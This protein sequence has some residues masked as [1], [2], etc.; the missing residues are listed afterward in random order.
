MD[1]VIPKTIHYC[2]FGKKPLNDEAIRCI[3]SWKKYFPD[4]QIVQWDE[5]NFDFSKCDYAKEAYES[6]KWAF[7]SDYARFKI[8]HEH[9]GIYFDTDVEVIKS[10]DD[11]LENGPF[12][13]KERSPQSFKMINPGLGMAAFPKMKFYEEVV[14]YYEKIHYD[15]EEHIT[16]CDHVTKMFQENGYKGDNELEVIGGITLYPIEYFCPRDYLTGAQFLTNNSHSIHLYS[17]T[18]QSEKERK[19][20][21]F[22]HKLYEKVKLNS[23][24]CFLV[25][26]AM[27]LYFYGVINCA[28]KFMKKIR[29][30]R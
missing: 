26:A 17:A 20:M 1:L 18:W 10:F 19:F 8:L 29:R 14:D 5:S 27:Y 2:W 23:N 11:I 13:G 4:Y 30:K 24:N 7:V 3:E 28:K 25:K 22:E 16:I 15:P 9:G 12:F 6:K 21:D